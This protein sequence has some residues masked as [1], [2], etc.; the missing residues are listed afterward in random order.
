MYVEFLSQN[1]DKFLSGCLFG[2]N[3]SFIINRPK[4]KKWIVNACH[5]VFPWALESCIQVF[6]LLWK[7][8][9]YWVFCFYFLLSTSYNY[10]SFFL[11]QY[12]VSVSFILYF[13]FSILVLLLR[14]KKTHPCIFFPSFF[15][16]F[17]ICYIS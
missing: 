13:C 6:P 8:L 7:T 15:S 12:L 4:L 5:V 17:I 2:A 9:H 3:F 16:Y 11:I 14:N 10:V 1:V